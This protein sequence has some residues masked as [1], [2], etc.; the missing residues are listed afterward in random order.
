M[1]SIAFPTNF[2]QIRERRDPNRG[3]RDGNRDYH[4]FCRSPPPHGPGGSDPT[5]SRRYIEPG[6]GW[7]WLLR[8]VLTGTQ[9]DWRGRRLPWGRRLSV[10]KRLLRAGLGRESPEPSGCGVGLATPPSWWRVAPCF[11]GS[12]RG[13]AGI[14]QTFFCASWLP[15]D[16][17]SCLLT[18]PPAF[19]TSLFS[20]DQMLF[21]Q[22]K[23][24][25]W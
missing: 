20:Y 5:P 3:N 13:L 25:F 10:Y 14:F 21:C 6:G 22:K 15:R 16:Q 23:M 2:F 17:E 7:R 8:P 19:W 9:G 18:S 4:H 24:G 11:F 12:S 1:T